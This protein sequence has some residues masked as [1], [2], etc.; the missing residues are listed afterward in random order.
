MGITEDE[1]DHQFM[2]LAMEQ[3]QLAEQQG[4]V[5][6]GAVLVKSGE[7]IAHGHNQVISLNDPCA[8][9]EIQA[10]KAA[11]KA[12]GNYRLVD[13]HLYVTLEPCVM[14]TGALIHARIG[15]LIYGAHDPKT[16]VISSVDQITERTY[17]NHYFDISAGV[18]GD[19]CSQMLSD[20]FKR[21]R[22]AKR[23][24]RCE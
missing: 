24:S 10:L 23:S 13:C 6:V 16:G 14:C 21:R 2:H 11:G 20:F 3:A 8:H 9:A 7:V 18:M 15:R 17:H 1:Q 12:L 4:E 19:E 5:P 22:T